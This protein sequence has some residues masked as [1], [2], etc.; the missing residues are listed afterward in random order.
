MLIVDV[1]L[2]A[3]VIALIATNV[4]DKRILKE[5]QKLLAE[6]QHISE[7][8]LGEPSE[9]DYK[10]PNPHDWSEAVSDT[11]FT[12]K[13]PVSYERV[14]VNTTHC[15]NCKLVHRYIIKGYALAKKKNLL[16]VEGFYRSG[17]KVRNQGCEFVLEHEVIDI[18]KD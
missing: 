7:Y 1:V 10:E 16:G 17:V 13:S 9:I 12:S 4:R 3:A 14:V 2:G 8:M 11:I 5:N 6:N 15:K 18:T